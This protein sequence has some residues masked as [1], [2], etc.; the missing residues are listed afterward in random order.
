MRHPSSAGQPA[1]PITGS[2]K[3]QGPLTSRL[4]IRTPWIISPLPA[5]FTAEAT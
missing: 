3:Q 5:L 1:I 2:T 4:R